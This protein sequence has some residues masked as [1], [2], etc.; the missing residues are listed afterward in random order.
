MYFN[1]ITKREWRMLSRVDTNRQESLFERDFYDSFNGNINMKF[2]LFEI[3]FIEE[4]K[5]VKYFNTIDFL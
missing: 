4:K 1:T 2:Y 5:I 3:I